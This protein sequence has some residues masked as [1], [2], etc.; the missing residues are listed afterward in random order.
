MGCMEAIQ[1]H[2]S[3]TEL[4][5]IQEKDYINAIST[6]PLDQQK[7]AIMC[8][9]DIH[10]LEVLHYLQN[11]R[12]LRVPEDVGVMGFDDIDVLKYVQPQLA[13]VNYDIEDMGIKAV[14]YLLRQINEPN[15]VKPEKLLAY[16][17]IAGKSL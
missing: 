1:S 13:T 3:A 12:S 8:T 5:I 10:A 7:T 4:I 9:C 16:S 11:V 6:L 17:L 14:D 2:S 15:A